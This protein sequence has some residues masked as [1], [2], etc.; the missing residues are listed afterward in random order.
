MTKESADSMWGY[1]PHTKAKHDIL[2]HYLAG[3]YGKLSAY[4]RVLFFDGFAGRGRYTDGSVGS[5]IIA[6]RTVLEHPVKERSC[7]FDFL[8]VERDTRNAGLLRQSLQE[9]E[10]EF[11]GLPKNVKYRVE[12]G[13]FQQ[14]ATELAD[15]ERRGV[16]MFA[17]VDP[18]GYSGVP[19]DLIRRMTRFKRVEVFVNLM[20]DHLGRF[21]DQEGQEAA[22]GGLYGM[23]ADLVMAEWER[24]QD[25][26]HAHLRDL[27]AR[28]LRTIAGF[29]Y[30]TSFAMETAGGHV[31][32]YL[33][34]G[35]NHP[36]G[37]RLMK[38]AMWKV[39]PENGGAFS[40]RDAAH[41]ALF[42]MGAQIEPLKIALLRDYA[43][44]SN[45][46]LS[47]IKEAVMLGPTQFRETHAVDAIRELK[48][49]GQVAIKSRGKAHATTFVTFH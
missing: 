22:V 47:E 44:R 16:P 37:V 1:P 28:Q 19:M 23:R 27:Y 33:L 40:D 46:P 20:V 39:D 21:V 12:T 8:F 2:Q 34:H 41:S 24:D 7:T 43:G 10:A 14:L 30:V 32:Y 6:L 38:A 3:W 45:I 4:P 36:D 5:P 25:P 35:T 26:R 17:F 42:A 15:Q 48:L 49:E 31:G 13:T 11:G 9:L 29:E 18:F